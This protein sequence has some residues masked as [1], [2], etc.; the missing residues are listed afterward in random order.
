[1]SPCCVVHCFIGDPP[2]ICSYCVCLGVGCG[3]VGVWVGV[4]V[5]LFCCPLFYGRS[6]PDQLVLCMVVSVCMFG[7][8]CVCA[9]ASGCVWVCVCVTLFCCPLFYRRATADQLVLCVYVSM[10][11]GAWVR[12][13]VGGC[14]GLR[15]GGCVCHLV[16]LSIVL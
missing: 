11:V 7:C 12:G 4:C 2:P 3:R 10:W 13:C 15:V 8:A 9:C 14:V 5:T 6:T 16:L 1:M